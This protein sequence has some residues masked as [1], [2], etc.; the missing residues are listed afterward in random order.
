MGAVCPSTPDRGQPRTHIP[1]ASPQTPALAGRQEGELYLLPLR[2]LWCYCRS[3]Q[4]PLLMLPHFAQSATASPLDSRLGGFRL[5]KPQQAG[6]GGSQSRAAEPAK[7]YLDGLGA[8]TLTQQGW[9]I[10]HPS[11]PLG[12]GV[13][14]SRGWP[15]G[16]CRAQSRHGVQGFPLPLKGRRPVPND[17]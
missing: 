17:S 12:R 5:R 7:A 6:R 14:G 3:R 16:R 9:G 1:G 15:L 8:D 4:G 13:I 10:S 11:P 2:G